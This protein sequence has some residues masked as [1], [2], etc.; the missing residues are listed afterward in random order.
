[1]KEGERAGVLPAR[2]LE[3]TWEGVR[4][5]GHREAPEEVGVRASLIPET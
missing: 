2:G 1:M 3:A 5:S 4:V